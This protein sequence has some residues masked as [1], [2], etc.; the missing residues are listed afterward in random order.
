MITIGDP[1]PLGTFRTFYR[2]TALPSNWLADMPIV[3]GESVLPEYLSQNSFPYRKRH[4]KEGCF[5]NGYNAVRLLGGWDEKY[6]GNVVKPGVDPSEFD[7][8]Y[9]G[10]GGHLRYRW[11]L[12]KERLDPLQHNGFLDNTT[13]VL[14]NVP[15]C[16]PSGPGSGPF[17]QVQ[18]PADRKEW[19]C[20]IE[21]L[22]R[23]LVK[24]YGA[25]T[26]EKLRFRIGTEN[27]GSAARD[28]HNRFD[29]SE[30]RFFEHY[31]DTAEAVKRVLPRAKV[32][33]FNLAGL[34]Q[35]LDTHLINYL[36]LAEYCVAENLPLDFVAHSL[37]YV[38]MF[39]YQSP[40]AGIDP[41][42]D[43]DKITN[44]D[45]D[46][47]THY[48]TD[49]WQALQDMDARFRDVPVE[50]HEY[51]TLANELGL[52]GVDSEARFAAQHFHTIVNLL[53]GG[54]SRLTHW[55]ALAPF[56]YHRDFECLDGLGWLFMVF[57]H[58]EGGEAYSIPIAHE[59]FVCTKYKCLAVSLPDRVVTMLSAFNVYRSIHVRERVS[60]RLPVG[61]G[62]IAA[63]GVQCTT[64]HDGNSPRKAFRDDLA[65]AGLLP[66]D[67]S[68][69]S[70][71]LPFTSREGLVTDRRAASAVAEKNA[72]RYVELL[73]GSLTLAPLSVAY[74]QDDGGI[75]IDAELRPPEVAVFVLKRKDAMK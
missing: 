43:H 42:R 51:G 48:Y 24:L 68:L 72:E 12:L 21:T 59:S 71:I 60:V 37:Y 40:L 32:G 66:D 64:L 73:K 67:Y 10:P 46:E 2:Q 56:P 19:N 57:D 22:C 62:P 38:P 16:F 17:G 8:A 65:R 44:C 29:G 9:R 33:P 54:L 49:F 20:F 3:E 58:L 1:I 74:R 61:V 25:E 69:H 55:G 39:G 7:M 41:V 45:P 18:P 30:E 52:P 4:P 75:E 47:K 27:Q 28:G 6:A 14:D 15:W 70:D 53:E 11:N 50:M 5:I 23:Q 26:A 63:T 35:G 36:R 34:D 31:R 13:L